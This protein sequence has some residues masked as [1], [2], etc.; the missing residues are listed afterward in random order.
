MSEIASINSGVLQGGRLSPL[1]Y[2]IS[3]SDPVAQIRGGL[4]PIDA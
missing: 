1:L 2:N 3:V 4:N